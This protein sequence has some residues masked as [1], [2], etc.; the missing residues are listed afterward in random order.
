MVKWGAM[1]QEQLTFSRFFQDWGLIIVASC[2]TCAG[3]LC[4]KQARIQ[5][6]GVFSPFFL[7]G[8][9]LFTLN[10]LAFSKA[11]EGLPLSAAYPVFS[12]LGFI[13]V[14]IASIFIFEESISLRQWVGMGLVLSGLFCI[15]NPLG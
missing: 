1:H 15:V 11:L 7:L 14:A 8:L 5:G 2:L 3:N 12:G 13:L 6:E 9:F 4:I 10:M